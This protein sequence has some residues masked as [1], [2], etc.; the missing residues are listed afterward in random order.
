MSITGFELFVI[1]SENVTADIL[2]W[3][4]YRKPAPGIVEALLDANP[5]IALVH[6][7]TPFLPVGM[8]VRVPIDL[9]ILSGAPQTSKIPASAMWGPG[10]R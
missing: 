3:K 8:Y 9:V 5:Q 10:V 4:R 6:K 2:V 1:S 7:T